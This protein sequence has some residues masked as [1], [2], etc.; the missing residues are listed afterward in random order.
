MTASV[1]R[2]RAANLLNAA[3]RAG[4]MRRPTRCPVCGV[5]SRA[6]RIEAHHRDHAQPLDVEW[7]CSRCHGRLRE[8]LLMWGD[9]PPSMRAVVEAKAKREGLSMR[10]LLLTLLKQ[11]T[12]EGTPGGG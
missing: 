2:R 5:G 6:R 1:E 10:A 7:V 12:R 4:H 11:W 3:V 8:R 9:L